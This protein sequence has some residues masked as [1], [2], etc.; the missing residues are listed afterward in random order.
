M[1]TKEFSF[2]HT[3]VTVEREE[4]RRSSRHLFFPLTFRWKHRIKKKQLKFLRN[5]NIQQSQ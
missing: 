3:K 4:R 2:S 5:G 1:E